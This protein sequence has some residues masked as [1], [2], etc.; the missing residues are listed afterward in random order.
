MP[1]SLRGFGPPLRVDL[2]SCRLCRRVSLGEEAHQTSDSR[3]ECHH[4]HRFMQA[5]RSAAELVPALISSG[6]SPT[7]DCRDEGSPIPPNG[8]WFPDKSASTLTPENWK[9]LISHFH[10]APRNG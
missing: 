5:A 6:E 8:I 2:D 3:T 9:L 1:G 4:A 10:M 7:S